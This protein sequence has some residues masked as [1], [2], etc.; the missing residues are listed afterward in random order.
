M[1]TL[2]VLFW[3]NVDALAPPVADPRH[4]TLPPHVQAAPLYDGTYE[5]PEAVG[6]KGTGAAPLDDGTYDMPDGFAATNTGAKAAPLDDGTY[7][8]PDGFAEANAAT[9]AV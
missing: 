6:T 1:T 8:M 7:D 2:G 4:P 5:M 3:A 9:S